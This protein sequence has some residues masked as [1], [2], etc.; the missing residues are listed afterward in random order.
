MRP[1][2]RALVVGIV[3][4]VACSKAS[5]TGDVDGDVGPGPADAGDDVVDGPSVPDAPASIDAPP[6]PDSPPGTPDAPPPPPDAMPPM[7]ADAANVCP[8][9]PCDIHEQCGC[10]A[11]QA[12][13][14]DFTDL[15][16]NACR[17]AG[18]GDENDTCPAVT[19]CAAGY[20]CVGNGTGD[21]CEKWCD[22]DD[23]CVAPK[24][25]CV[26]QLSD[27]TM[28][29]PGAVVCSSNCNPTAVVTGGVCP[30]AW[31]CT[32]QS[33]VFQGADQDIVD[34]TPAGAGAIGAACADDNACVAGTVCIDTTNDMVT[35]PTCTRICTPPGTGTCPVGD[36]C[37]GFNPPFNVGG[38][39]Y[40]VCI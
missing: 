25:K 39:I 23:D 24:G 34:C 17:V 16:G 38:T 26:I 21:A 4:V 15:M 33:V 3:F 6:T 8:T 10:P 2:R 29:I 36:V 12:C 13:D 19:T 20:V 11:N 28:D 32:L 27:G 31:K 22:A 18:A 37:T 40:G 14:I 1:M 9:M 7:M 5:P 35:N 30:A